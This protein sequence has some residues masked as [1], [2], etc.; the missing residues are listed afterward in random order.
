MEECF[1]IE[2]RG[3]LVVALGLMVEPSF[4]GM[5]FAIF[6]MNRRRIITM[7]EVMVCR[8]NRVIVLR[9]DELCKHVTYH[10]ASVDGHVVYVVA[11]G[12]ILVR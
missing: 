1:S 4:K 8:R 12:G 2:L 6:G 5:C 11:R 3:I 7:Q 10:W 9:R